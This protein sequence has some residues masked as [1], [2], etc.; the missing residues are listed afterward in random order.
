MVAD[1]KGKMAPMA[2]AF[3]LVHDIQGKGNS[4]I[5]KVLFDTGESSSM[6]GVG[7]LPHG[8]AVTPAPAEMINTLAGTMTTEGTITLKDMRLPKFEQYNN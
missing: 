1:E 2:C 5:L 7:I 6:A 3:M 4:K 8:T